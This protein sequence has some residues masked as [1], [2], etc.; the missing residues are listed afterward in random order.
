MVM[1]FHFPVLEAHDTEREDMQD[2]DLYLYFAPQEFAGM[3]FV[4]LV[5][6]II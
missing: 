6:R 2:L 4:Y 3:P 5:L 1:I